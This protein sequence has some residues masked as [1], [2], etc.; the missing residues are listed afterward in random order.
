[1]EFTLAFGSKPEFS[2]SFNSLQKLIIAW[3]K[4][5]KVQNKCLSLLCTFFCLN[6]ILVH[7]TELYHITCLNFHLRHQKT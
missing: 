3:G 1:M 2:F 6:G 5:E 4:R 7:H